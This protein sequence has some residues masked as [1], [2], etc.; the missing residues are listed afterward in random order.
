MRPVARLLL[1][2]GVTWKE[3]AELT[4]MTLVGVAAEEFGQHGRPA[5]SSRIALATG[6]G[7]REVKRLRDLLATPG[8]TSAS[9]ALA[10]LN[11]ASRLLS[12]WHRDPDFTGPRGKPRLLAPHG[13]PSF[14]SLARRYAP[15]I[16]PT[17]ILRELKSVGAVRET[18]TGKL[19]VIERYY[20]PTQLATESIVRGGSALA[21][22]ATT[23]VHNLFAGRKPTRFEARA[24]N[25]RVKRTAAR[26]FQ[27]Y[28]ER[29]GLEFLEQAD[30]WLSAREA[31]EDEP[32]IRLG[33]GVYMIRDD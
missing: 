30:D 32:A 6:L 20:M 29:H 8:A 21:D 12:G 3:I 1:R 11:L 24:S 28:L 13:E 26:A 4:K 18:P 7:R 27:T 10:T 5:S 15:D 9:D 19:R 2:S 33:V 16:P 17:A 31:G 25:L 14:E 23:M 22:F